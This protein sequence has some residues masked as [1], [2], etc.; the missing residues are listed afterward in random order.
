MTQHKGHRIHRSAAPPP[1]MGEEKTAERI[2]RKVGGVIHLDEVGV[3]ASLVV[4]TRLVLGVVLGVV[5]GRLVALGGPRA[6]S[7]RPR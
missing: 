6:A 2:R 7:A 5:R 1:L 3:R 4:P